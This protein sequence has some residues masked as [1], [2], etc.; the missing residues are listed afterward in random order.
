MAAD[1]ADGSGSE[2]LGELPPRNEPARRG[3]A[4]VYLGTSDFAASVLRALADGPNRPALVVT[5][6]D[7]KQ[8]RGR[9]VGP[10]P[11]AV[12]ARELGIDVDQPASVNDEAAR[13]RIAAV[14]PTGVILCAFGALVKEPL[15]SDYDILNVHP[16]LL[17]R[18]R[19][20]APVERAMMAGDAQTGVSI[21]RLVAELDAGPV[22]AQRPEPILPTDDYATLAAR[23]QDISVDLLRQVLEELP[24]PE[25]QPD[26]GITYADKL[27]AEDRTLDLTR[28]PEENVRVVRAL[29][30][31]IGARI[32]LPSGDFLGVQEASIALDGSLELVTV[33]PAGGRSMAYSEYLRGHA[34]AV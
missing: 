18:W 7:A 1:A 17:P 30:P 2:P 6:P 31:H 15:L 22:Y 25:P 32:A 20:A 10:P 16:S 8:G 26:L 29:H 19:G 3:S 11:V 9:K 21:M 13:A 34:P 5:R 23:L 14:Q 28:P 33:Q 4:I 24:T 12:A 27:T